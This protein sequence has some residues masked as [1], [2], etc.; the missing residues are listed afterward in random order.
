MNYFFED[1]ILEI[2]EINEKNV[3]KDFFFK[4]FRRCRLFRKV[5]D[6]FLGEFFFNY[7]L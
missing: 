7:N 2:M 1:D 3:G 5:C 4:L 6:G